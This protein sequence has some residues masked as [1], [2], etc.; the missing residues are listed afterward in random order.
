MVNSKFKIGKVQ[1]IQVIGR[2]AS[3]RVTGVRIMGDNGVANVGKE[4]AVRRLF[5]N[6][7]SGM[8]VLWIV[9][10]SDDMPVKFIF[11]G[12]GWGHGVGMCQAGACGLAQNGKSYKDI[13]AHYFKAA[14]LK[15]MY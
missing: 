8:F 12:G 9:R 3:G 7:K 2:G 13:L 14:E 1:D 15:K 4:L 10:D 6:L 11:S 5:G